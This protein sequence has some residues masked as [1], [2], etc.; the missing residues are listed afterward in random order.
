MSVSAFAEL[1]AGQ[2]GV[3]VSDAAAFQERYGSG[4]NILG[5]YTGNLSNSGEPISLNDGKT[6]AA[7]KAFTYEDGT[8]VGEED[9]PTTPD[10][11]GPSLVVLNTDGDYDDGNNWAASTTTNGTP[12]EAEAATLVGDLNNDGY[13]GSADLSQLLAYWGQPSTASARSRRRRP[14]Q[15]RQRQHARPEPAP[16]QLGRGHAA[17]AADQQPRPRRQT[18]TTTRSKRTPTPRLNPKTRP[19]RP[20]S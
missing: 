16:R 11:D 10:G 19:S 9:W 1:A 8:G 7:I 12:G 20:L 15:R 6:T 14:Q 13:V 2:R 4:I 5:T 18:T 3:F 17:D